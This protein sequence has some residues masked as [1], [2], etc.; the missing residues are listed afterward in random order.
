M[1]RSSPPARRLAAVVLLPWL[2][3]CT[4]DV[5]A[6]LLLTITGA[7]GAPA[8]DAV[9][10]RTFD[11]GGP[12]QMFTSFPTPAPQPDGRLGTVVI[13]PARGGA[14]SLRIHA[15]GLRRGVPVSEG[16]ARVQLAAGRQATATLTL[17]AV[18]AADGDGDGVPD[19][20]DNCAAVAN[21]R[22]ED[23]NADG[24][25]DACSGGGAPGPSITAMSDAASDPAATADAGC[26]CEA[27]AQPAPLGA[28]CATGADCRS[29]FCAD[30][31]CCE[32]G[33]CG[34]PCRACNLP[35]AAGS[36]RDLPAEAAPRAGGCPMEPVSS[37]GR[38]GK[39]DGAGACQRHPPGA[40]C[41]PGRCADGMETAPS[42]CSAEGACRPGRTRACADG[43]ACKG[44]LCATSCTT[45]AECTR[46]RY[47]LNAA[48]TPRRAAGA[49]CKENR[50][51]A[52]GFCADGHCC[53]VPRCAPGA[54][55]RGADGTCVNQRSQGD[56]CVRGP[57]CETG[58]CVDGICCESACT[59]TCR[60][61]AQPAT[62]GRCVPIAAGLDYNASPQCMPPRQCQAGVCR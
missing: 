11:G 31:V 37:C 4:A 20:I 47:C 13:Y 29:S 58:F 40:P 32:A 14:G 28:P 25:G 17:T 6:S 50:E 49:V 19:E 3:A 30:G 27:R 41:A 52:T 46:D 42:T 22:Q 55:C 2:A 21:V 45:E 51:C 59:E 23:G 60:Q 26:A 10:V 33:D 1:K 43:L 7:P 34:G 9:Q 61:C 57:E 62:V 48:C 5:P 18:P 16:T 8:P 56:P 44:E 36:C 24:K 54:W 35:G 39:C 53:G 15:Q 38:T 12:L